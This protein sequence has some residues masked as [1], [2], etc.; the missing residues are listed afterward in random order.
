[1]IVCA[2]TI[3]LLAI[4]L[5]LFLLRK[6]KMQH[7]KENNTDSMLFGRYVYFVQYDYVIIFLLR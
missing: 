4:L 1:M 5:S 2:M 3:I 7:R 6:K